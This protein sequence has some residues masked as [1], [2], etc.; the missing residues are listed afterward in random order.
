MNLRNTLISQMP[1][2]E[3]KTGVIL[4]LLLEEVVRMAQT[5][6]SENILRVAMLKTLAV[7]HNSQQ[8]KCLEMPHHMVKTLRQI[9]WVV[10]E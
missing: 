8:E 4:S 2:I 10:T 7:A 6:V 5:M 9:K 1:K 3:I